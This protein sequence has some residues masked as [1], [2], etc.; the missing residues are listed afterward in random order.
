M[1]DLTAIDILIDPDQAMVAGQAVNARLLESV[2]SG[3]ALDDHH[4]PRT[5]PR[6]QRY[7]R[8]ADLDRA[9]AACRLCSKRSTLATWHSP[10][11]R[12][13]AWRSTPSPRRAY[14]DRGEA[15]PRRARLPGQADRRHSL[16]YRERRHRRSTYTEAEPDINQDTI[17]YIEHHVPDHSSQNYLGHVNVASPSSTT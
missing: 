11:S 1:T 17:D 16:L 10:R 6:C 5:S 12:C 15:G 14:R 3:F 9:F 4:R 2:P 7:V 8:S 13:G